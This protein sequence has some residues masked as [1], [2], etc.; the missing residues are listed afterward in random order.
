MNAAKAI[1]I[2]VFMKAPNGSAC[3][4]VSRV[5]P[6]FDMASLF[7][8]SLAQAQSLFCSLS[9]DQQSLSG[10]ELRPMMP[11][12]LPPPRFL[13]SC[14]PFLPSFPHRCVPSYS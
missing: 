6:V 12:L 13:F 2:Y 4:E 7:G 9:L 3:V 14:P 8:R 11:P 1:G 10:S 5:S